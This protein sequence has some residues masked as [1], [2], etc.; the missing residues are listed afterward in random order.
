VSRRYEDEYEEDDEYEDDE[1]LEG[2]GAEAGDALNRSL[3]LGFLA[4]VPMFLVYEFALVATR[5]TERNTSELVLFR[6]FAPFGE[7]S[8]LAR[9]LVLGAAAGYALVYCLR[10]HWALGPRVARIVLEGGIGA[11]AI[12]PALIGLVHLLGDSLPGLVLSGDPETQAPGL[13]QAAFVF[14]AGA[15]EEIVFRVGAYS[16]LYF[17]F[18]R[19]GQFFG[20]R[21]GVSKI[22]GELAG[23]FGSA[24]LFSAFHLA[25]FVAWL[26][27]GGEEFD[28][29]I[30]TYRAL[31]GMLLGILFRWRGPG[32]AAWTHGLFNL[33]LLLG[34]GPEV[35]L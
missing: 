28:L 21:L 22:A 17:C 6:L 26:G 16:A 24:A 4:M 11:V 20:L 14:G 30:F 33:A 9:R 34:A 13:A 27:P 10:R 3:A 5:G 18:L 15:Y 35:F 8:D 19:V 2:E 32:V 23:L 7:W 1:E 12:G 25:V 31:A 29:S